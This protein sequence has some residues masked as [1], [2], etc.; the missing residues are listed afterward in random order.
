MKSLTNIFIVILIFSAVLF[1]QD[2]FEG[3]V[4]FK[5][6]TDGDEQMIDYYVKDGN[7][8]MEVPGQATGSMIMKDGKMLILMP[9]QKMFMEMPMNLSEK[10]EENMEENEITPDNL[11][12]YKTGDT[13]EILGYETEK[14][15]YND[16][17]SE[18]E[19][20]VAKDLGTMN[21]FSNP[22]GK[23]SEW[24]KK[25]NEINYFPMLMI[26]KNKKGE[27]KTRF[28]VVEVNEETLPANMFEAPSDYKKMDMMGMPKMKAE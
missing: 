3:K 7:F 13:Q 5:V 28:E 25:L 21:F 27:E 22:M 2:G 6:T 26:S 10:F 16:E 14:Y 18:V 12:N 9:E 1:A 11:E 23:Q 19:V 8:K 20:W 24:Q 4:K 15:V 17:E